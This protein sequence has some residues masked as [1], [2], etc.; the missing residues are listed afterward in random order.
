M[1]NITILREAVTVKNANLILDHNTN[2]YHLI[3]YDT[4]IFTYNVNTESI[5]KLLP[6]S[7]SSNRAIHQ[8]LRH[9]D[10][11]IEVPKLCKK[12]N[13]YNTKEL[14]EQWNNG[15]IKGGDQ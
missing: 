9:L 8:A 12:L 7:Q 6:V 10:I 13:G 3:H 4:E 15:N 14:K 5:T 1:N 2:T 11:T